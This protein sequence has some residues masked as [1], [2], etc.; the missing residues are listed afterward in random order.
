MRRTGRLLVVLALIALAGLT[1]C[2]VPKGRH[3]T[4]RY[5]SP[6]D[7]FNVLPPCDTEHFIPASGLCRGTQWSSPTTV[8]SGD[9]VGHTEYTIGW[10]TVPSGDTYATSLETFTGT[11]KG[12]GTGTMTYRQFGT[13]DRKGTMRFEWQVVESLGTGE[14]AG[15]QGHGTLT[16]ASRPDQSS[17]GE[18]S[19]EIDCGR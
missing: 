8:V 4:A 11:V 17:E 9:W 19:G 14:L 6:P 3:I 5:E 12:C 15:L 1:A 13:A 16:G 10:V 18:F 2:G 7:Q